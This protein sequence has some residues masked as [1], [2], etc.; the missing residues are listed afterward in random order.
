M[1][2]IGVFNQLNPV[3]A[4][5]ELFK[6]CGSGNWVAKVMVRFPFEEEQ[7]LFDIVMEAWYNECNED[8]YLEAFS[9]HPRI[10]DIESLKE[11]FNSTRDWAGDEQAG[12][13]IA[14]EKTIVE[15][16]RLNEVYYNKF[17][18]IF[19]VCATGKSAKEMLQLLKARIGHTIKGEIAVAKGEQHKITLIRIN[20]LME[21][22]NNK[23]NERS[24]IT[25]HVLDT[26]LGKPGK[27]I[28]IKL[29][30]DSGETVAVGVT[31]GDGRISDLLPS[32]RFLAAGDYTMHFETRD[33][34]D[35]R[36]VIG[37]YPVV[38]IHFTVVDDSHYHVPLLI[39]P[40]GYSTYR[41]S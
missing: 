37:F 10:G 12:V 1:Y 23:W 21:L 32:G 31:D 27:G 30:S 22:K 26:S 20:K 39:N 15:L 3:Q 38:D 8:D 24:Q 35:K 19:I 11:K 29:L 34:F 2:T 18:F 25:T 14:E 7:Q 17:G 6:C 9:H 36:G 33:Y 28:A 40:Y 5:E 41:G 4:A 16:A 13:D